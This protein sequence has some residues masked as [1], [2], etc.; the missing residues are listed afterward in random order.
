VK[1]LV[2]HKDKPLI[3]IPNCTTL[4]DTL[5]I[6]EKYDIL[7]APVFGER[8]NLLGF[9]DVLDITAYIFSAW[10]NSFMYL[11][12]LPHLER[13]Y[14]H[15]PAFDVVVEKIVNFSHVDPVVRVT[16]ATTLKELLGLFTQPGHIN[17]LHR[18]LVEENGKIVQ[19]VS[20]SDIISFASRHTASMEK[21]KISLSIRDLSIM[22]PVLMVRADS[23]FCDTLELL[24]SNKISG[25]ALID[26]L[27][28]IVGNFS[29]SDLRGLNEHAFDYFQGSTLQ[30]LVK[31]T[32]GGLL[33]PIT[34]SEQ[35][36]LELAIK[37]ISAQHI[38]RIYVADSSDHP[39]GVLTLGDIIQVIR[40]KMGKEEIHN[41]K[42]HV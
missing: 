21:S 13:K 42:V 32:R 4:R 5:K 26:H 36:S 15:N 7:S 8:N 2:K 29:A 14:H 9:V 23:P 24:Y 31:G 16:Y 12:D 25:L 3:Q 18:V 10:K 22:H 1:D 6:L 40:W 28:R 19:L 11:Q 27:G 34:I 41:V 35:S 38:H 20:Q 39:L 37:N 17:R 30:F 33:A